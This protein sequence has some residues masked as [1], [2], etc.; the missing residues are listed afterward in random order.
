M[1]VVTRQK[2]TKPALEVQRGAVLQERG[3]HTST[4]EACPWSAKE[5]SLTDGLEILPTE[6]RDK[7]SD[8]GLEL[9]CGFWPASENCTRRSRR[10]P[11]RMTGQEWEQEDKKQPRTAWSAEVRPARDAGNSGG[12]RNVR[13][14]RGTNGNMQRP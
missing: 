9:L 6:Q 2:R 7:M 5:G 8:V 14:E 4:S 13:E 11:P 3:R 1:S 10:A 12:R